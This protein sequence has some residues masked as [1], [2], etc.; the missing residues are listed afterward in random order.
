MID[1][2]S[3]NTTPILKRSAPLDPDYEERKKFMKEYDPKDTL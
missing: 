3:Y 1:A 2:P